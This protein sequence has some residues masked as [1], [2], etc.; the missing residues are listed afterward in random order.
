[1]LHK[2]RRLTAFSQSEHFKILQQ[3]QL[4][5]GQ[6]GQFRHDLN[7]Q[8]EDVVTSAQPHLVVIEAGSDKTWRLHG[9]GDFVLVWIGRHDAFLWSITFINVLHQPLK[10]Q[11]LALPLI[12]VATIGDE[13][14]LPPYARRLARTAYDFILQD[15][16]GTLIYT[17]QD[18]TLTKLHY[19]YWWLVIASILLG[20][21]AKIGSAQVHAFTSILAP[22]AL[23]GAPKNPT[24]AGLYIKS[25]IEAILSASNSASVDSARY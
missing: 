11:L 1:M 4:S 18:Q 7:R 25:I 3:G 20:G 2:A 24:E 5:L 9:T 19:P 6:I 16:D 12:A 23:P 14:L 8:V 21:V 22:A 17:S 15:G 13:Q 10:E